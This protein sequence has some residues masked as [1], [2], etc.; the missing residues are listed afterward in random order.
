MS[1]Q[2]ERFVSGYIPSFQLEPTEGWVE[3]PED[4][5][6]LRGRAVL[7]SLDGESAQIL[8]LTRTPTADQAELVRIP[9]EG[10]FPS[11]S[12]V[13]EADTLVITPEAQAPIRLERGVADPETPTGPN[14]TTRGR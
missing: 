14:S 8:V 12:L 6:R 10:G 7:S 13:V 1:R 5:M 2:G 4:P 11:L 3:S 9:G